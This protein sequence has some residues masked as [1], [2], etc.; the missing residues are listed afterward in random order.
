M[1]RETLSKPRSR[2]SRT[3]PSPRPPSCPSP[4]KLFD[5]PGNYADLKMT[6]TYEF[7]SG[8][9]LSSPSLGAGSSRAFHP[10]LASLTKTSTHLDTCPESVDGVSSLCITLKAHILAPFRALSRPLPA[11]TSLSFRTSSL[12]QRSCVSLVPTL[13]RLGAPFNQS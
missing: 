12:C 1:R 11:F 10:R 3:V 13:Q 9:Y 5:P 4:N 2:F 7:Q 6:K 8:R